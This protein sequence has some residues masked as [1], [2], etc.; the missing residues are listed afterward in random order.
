[1]PLPG[2]GYNQYHY[3]YG[4]SVGPGNRVTGGSTAAPSGNTTVK[5]KAGKTVQR[6]GFGISSG[7]SKGSGGS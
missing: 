7:G 4:G 5:T 1:M 6:G 2:G 3:N